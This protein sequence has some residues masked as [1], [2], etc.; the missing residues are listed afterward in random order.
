MQASCWAVIDELKRKHNDLAGWVDAYDRGWR[1]IE[2]KGAEFRV[3]KKPRHNLSGPFL[4]AHRDP[5]EL[6]RLTTE[7]DKPKERKS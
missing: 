3:R 6:K 4:L 7:A 1:L 5:E 2:A